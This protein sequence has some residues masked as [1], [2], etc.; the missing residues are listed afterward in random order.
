MKHGFAGLVHIRLEAYVHLPRKSAAARTFNLRVLPG[1]QQYVKQW[2][3]I[4]VGHFWFVP[5]PEKH[6]R[7]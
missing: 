1:P 6:K 4:G 2:P 7:H 5:F 3:F